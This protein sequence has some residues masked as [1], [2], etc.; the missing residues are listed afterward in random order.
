MNPLVFSAR[1]WALLLVIPATLILSACD[2]NPVDDDDHDEHAAEIEG[3][4]VV[5]NGA[6][7]WRVLEGEVTCADATCGFAIPAGSD[8]PLITVE[9]LDHDGDEIHGDELDSAF[10]LGHAFSQDGFAAFEQPVETER[11]TFQLE[12]VSAGTVA[13]QLQLLHNGHADFTTPPTTAGNAIQVVV[14]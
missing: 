14:E 11:W 9:F 7:V 13:F 10:S 6:E 1:R 12:G 3:I 4:A 5:M 8:T 2:S